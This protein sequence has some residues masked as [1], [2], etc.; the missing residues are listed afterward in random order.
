M[1]KSTLA[2]EIA[3]LYNLE[4][5][6]FFQLDEDGNPQAYKYDPSRLS[7]AHKWCQDRVESHMQKRIP[8]LAV[9]NV[10][11]KH[12]Q[13]KPY[14]ELAEKYKYRVFEITITGKNHGNIHGVSEEKIKQIE[15]GWEK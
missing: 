7:E 8:R 6:F 15:E 2:K 1:G 14:Y 10:F 3:P 5:D 11:Q 9:A 13:M 12:W 4:A